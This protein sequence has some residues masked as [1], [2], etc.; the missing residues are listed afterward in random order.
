MRLHFVLSGFA[1][2]LSIFYSEGKVAGARISANETPGCFDNEVLTVNHILRRVQG[3]KP[4][5]EF[6]AELLKY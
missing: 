1:P 5:L 2:R 4:V 3:K 6:T